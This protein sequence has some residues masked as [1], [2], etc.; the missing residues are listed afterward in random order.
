MMSKRQQGIEH[1]TPR[2]VPLSVKAATMKLIE[3][4]FDGRDINRE[5]N[6][7]GFNFFFAKTIVKRNQA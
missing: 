1:R 5:I 3:T 2:Y 7:F 4:K 6:L